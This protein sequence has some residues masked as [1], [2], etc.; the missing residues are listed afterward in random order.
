MVQ[1]RSSLIS[2]QT[3]RPQGGRRRGGWGGEEEEPDVRKVLEN[4]LGS[5]LD[6]DEYVPGPC[7][8]RQRQ[9]DIN[10]GFNSQLWPS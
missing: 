2:R 6:P 3:L 10:R 1:I 8:H 4:I 5:D 9:F 7:T